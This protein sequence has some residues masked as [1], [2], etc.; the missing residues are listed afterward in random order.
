M[1]IRDVIKET[2]SGSIAGVAA[3][4]GGG[5]P[6]A[7]IYYTKKSAPRKKRALMIRRNQTESALFN[8]FHLTEDDLTNPE[9]DSIGTKRWY[10]IDPATSKKELHRVNGPAIILASGG[11]EWWANGKRHRVDGPA[12]IY[13]NG[14]IAW[15]QN[16]VQHRDNMP[17]YVDRDGTQQWWR[18]GKLLKTETFDDLINNSKFLNINNE[19]W[20][21]NILYIDSANKETV[22]KQILI[23]FKRWHTSNIRLATLARLIIAMKRRRF[24][25]PELDVIKKSLDNELKVVNNNNTQ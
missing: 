17:A 4:L 9:I 19:E 24:Q 23:L 13:P 15:F 20:I 3:G 2:T 8:K 22:I 11:Q 18:N 5:D 14:T 10:R 7:S 16:G 1:K 25:W 6:A 12:V 21:K